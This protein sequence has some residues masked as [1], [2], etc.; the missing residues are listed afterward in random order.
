MEASSVAVWATLCCYA[1]PRRRRRRR[2]RRRSGKR[3]RGTAR[4]SRRGYRSRILHLNSNVMSM[5]F[6]RSRSMLFASIWCFRSLH[7]I[8]CNVTFLFSPFYLSFFFWFLVCKLFLICSI[9][10][11][12]NFCTLSCVFPFSFPIF[13]G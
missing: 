1:V 3:I 5:L 9:S 7:L 6:D 2:C 12:R 8:V 13:F 10:F 11:W 4:G